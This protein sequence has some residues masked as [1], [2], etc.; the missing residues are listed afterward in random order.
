MTCFYPNDAYVS[1]KRETGTNIIKFGLPQK[2]DQPTLS[3]PCGQ[4]LGC[5]LA[6][7]STW[8]IRCMHEAQ[9]HEQN[10]FITLTYNNEN[11]PYDH[12]L[13]PSHFTKFL[14]RLRH[15]SRTSFRYFMCG[16]YGENPTT[17]IRRPHYHAILFGLDF[18][19]REIFTE[20]EG[21]ITDTSDILQGI[22]GKGFTTVGNVDLDSCAYV[23]RYS[24]KKIN[25]SQLS[26]EKYHAHYQTTCPITGEI[27]QL[28]PEFANMSRGGKTS[29]LGGIG[30]TWYDLYHSDIFPHD[31][32]IYKGRNIKTPRYYENLL[33]S[34]DLPTFDE[35]KEKR[36]QQAQLHAANNTP[37]RL[38]VRET[39]T[40]RKLN[41]NFQRKLDHET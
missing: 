35:I 11:L 18:P 21:I 16:E 19:D 23:A 32:T 39:I 15:H 30:K 20:S 7:S 40:K 5:R 4:C 6:H 12:S 24:L 10:S 28:H 14:K 41:D 26:P 33:R 36:K 9:M 22:W 25:A 34:S 1:G 17:S 31:T 29:N 38:R 13:T 37:A 2:P 3:L 8:A 27:R